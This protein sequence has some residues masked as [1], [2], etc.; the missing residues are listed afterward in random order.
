MIDN[1]EYFIPVVSPEELTWRYG[2]SFAESAQNIM[3]SI[4]ESLHSLDTVVQ[5]KSLDYHVKCFHK[6]VRSLS[7]Y[8]TLLELEK[9]NSPPV[10][11]DYHRKMLQKLRG[12]KK[13]SKVSS[14]IN[15]F[16]K[17]ELIFSIRIFRAEEKGTNHVVDLQLNRGHPVLFLEFG[18]KFVHVLT[19]SLEPQEMQTEH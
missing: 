4:Y 13:Q 14:K 3:K 7:N 12:H 6:V 18:N 5:V 11:N 2:F 15:K 8:N 10:S 1:Q 17:V 9:N 16:S 19:A